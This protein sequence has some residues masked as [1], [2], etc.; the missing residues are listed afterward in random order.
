MGQIK[1]IKLHIVTDIKKIKIKMVKKRHLDDFLKTIQTF[2]I[3]S[4]ECESVLQDLTVYHSSS[5][6]ESS[7]T[8][9][10][11]VTCSSPFLSQPLQNEQQL[12]FFCTTC[13]CP[14]PN[15]I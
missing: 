8:I 15:A 11:D 1:N 5:P 10:E 3:F 14:F 12:K 9:D 6:N 2:N 4:S 13:N 7:S